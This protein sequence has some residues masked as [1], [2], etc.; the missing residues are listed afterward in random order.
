MLVCK[1]GVLGSVTSRL[2]AVGR[3]AFTNYLAQ[4]VLCTTIFYGFGLGLYGDVERTGQILIVFA[5]W[6]VQLVVSPLW[7]RRFRFGPFE[8]AWRSLTYG[9]LQPMRRG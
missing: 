5:V 9:R 2:A 6:A 4:S 1:K 7:L 8:W 3:T